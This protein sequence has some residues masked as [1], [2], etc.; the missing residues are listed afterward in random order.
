M[1]GEH[2]NSRDEFM[3]ILVFKDKIHECLLHYAQPL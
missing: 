1:V 2:G 3:M